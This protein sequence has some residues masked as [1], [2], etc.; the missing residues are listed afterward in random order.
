MPFNAKLAA[1]YLHALLMMDLQRTYSD[2][3]PGSLCQASDTASNDIMFHARGN[4]ARVIRV[5][6]E[7]RLPLTAHAASVWLEGYWKY[8]YECDDT[9]LP[10]MESVQRLLSEEA[11]DLLKEIIDAR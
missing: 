2:P 9:G 7:L 1:P 8:S 5:E 6:N 10:L 3:T 4:D 11:R